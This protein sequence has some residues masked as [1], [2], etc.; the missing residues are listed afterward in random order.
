VLSDASGDAAAALVAFRKA[1]YVDRT[2]V[3]ALLAVAAIYRRS[4]QPDRAQRALARAQ[5][6]L[7]G[8]SDDELILAE[9]P[10]TVGHLREVLN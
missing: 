7:L 3:P 5:Q 9:E 2:F 8:R 4:G 1:L 10:V 6:S